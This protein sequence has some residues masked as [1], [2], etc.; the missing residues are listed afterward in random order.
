MHFIKLMVSDS[1]SMALTVKEGYREDSDIDIAVI[2]DH[3][4]DN[5]F[6]DTSL[7]I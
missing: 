5:Y 3:L 1:N 7:L 4:S 6:D 2:V